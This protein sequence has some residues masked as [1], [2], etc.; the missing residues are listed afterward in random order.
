MTSDDGKREV[1]DAAGNP[2]PRKPTI[3]DRLRSTT[4]KS[5]TIILAISVVLAVLGTA[6]GNL[7]KLKGFFF[8]AQPNSTTPSRDVLVPGQ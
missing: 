4:L 6:V 3:A 2:I 8:R 7:E 1:L 5:K